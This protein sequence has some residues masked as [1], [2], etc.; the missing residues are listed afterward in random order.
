MVTLAHLFWLTL[1][2]LG[3]AYW[4]HAREM[5]ERALIAARKRVQELELEFLD[6]SVVLHR[7]RPIRDGG[8]QWRLLRRYRFEFSATGDERYQGWIELAGYRV[9]AIHLDPH[10]MSLH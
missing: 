9:R 2:G 4:L 10:R 1:L 5:K 3:I 6:D 8:G 7:L